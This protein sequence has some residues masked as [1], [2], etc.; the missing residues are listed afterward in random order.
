VAPGELRLARTTTR[1]GR[2]IQ[3]WTRA[4]RGA[5]VEGDQVAVVAIGGRIAAVWAQLTP[6]SLTPLSLTPLSLTPISLT[7]LSLTH[8]PRAG[9]RVLPGVDKGSPRLVRRATEGGLVVYRDRSNTVVHRYDPRAYGDLSS[10]YEERTVGDAL[11][12]GPARAVTLTDTSGATD[13]TADDGGAIAADTAVPYAAVPYAA[14]TF[15][16]DVSE[17]SAD[18]IAASILD[19]PTLAPNAWADGSGI[20][21]LDTDK[22]YPDDVVNEV[23]ADGLIWA[24]FLWNLRTD[25]GAD[26]ADEDSVALWYTVGNASVPTDAGPAE[27]DTGGDTGGAE[28]IDAWAAWRSVPLT[29]AGDA[30]SGTIPRQVATSRVRYFIQAASDDGTQVARA[31]G[32]DEEGVY[33]LSRGPPTSCPSRA[34]SRPTDPRSSPGRS[35]RTR[36]SSTAAGRST[37]CAS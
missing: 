10:T 22:R 21:E 27:G 11:L 28:E 36:A 9:E 5:P 12:T 23:H 18:Y 33:S 25:W 1:D 6:L 17:G 24:S 30:W 3:Q 14:G 15:A 4:W 29:R 16:G 32:G 34:S 26:A 13:V 7:P 31:D 37:R 20:R 19:D 35:P 8:G 2:V